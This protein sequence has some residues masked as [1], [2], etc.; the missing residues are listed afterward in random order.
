[1]W[2]KRSEAFTWYSHNPGNG[3]SGLAFLIA[4]FKGAEIPV[5]PAQVTQYKG[6]KDRH[7]PGSPGSC[8]LP[9]LNG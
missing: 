8:S 9:V 5:Q 1:M 6:Q 4:L 7:V 2:G 3:L